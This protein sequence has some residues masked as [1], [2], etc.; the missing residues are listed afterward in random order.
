[1]H[2]LNTYL[3]TIDGAIFAVGNTPGGDNQPQWN[4][5][6]IVD[7][8][9]FGLDPQAAAEAPRW[10]SFP[11][12]NPHTCAQAFVLTLDERFPESTAAA[13]EAKGHTVKRGG[14]NGAVQLIQVDPE[15][16][17]LMGGSDPRVDGMALGY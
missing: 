7:M 8:V 10:S 13:L 6:V 11:G 3:I 17:V 14:V 4:F 16:G 1:M 9:D 5:Q 2:T 15:T 12:A